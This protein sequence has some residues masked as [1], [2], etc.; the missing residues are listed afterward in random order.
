MVDSLS[1]DEKQAQRTNRKEL[2][3]TGTCVATFDAN[4]DFIMNW[5]ETAISTVPFEEQ[6][7]EDGSDSI[8][9]ENDLSQ[10]L[11]DPGHEMSSQPLE[12]QRQDTVS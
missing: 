4:K 2:E 5:F 8:F 6:T 9:K 12:N 10:S 11:E 7:A 1:K 3:D